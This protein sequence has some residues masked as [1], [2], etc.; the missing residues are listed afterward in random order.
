MSRVRTTM[1]A[2]LAAAALGSV[3][4]CGSLL[5][6]RAIQTFTDSLAASDLESMKASS[7]ATF[8][9]AALRDP[10]AVNDFDILKLP[11][12]RVKVVAEEEVSETEKLVTV[13]VG[14]KEKEMIYKLTRDAS[15][16]RWVVDDIVMQQNKQGLDEPITRSVAE[17]MDLLLTVREFLHNWRDGGREDL[18]AV[19]TPEF[20]EVLSGVAPAHLQQLTS[21]LVGTSAEKSRFKPEAWLDGD[22]AGVQLTLSTGKLLIELRRHEQLWRVNDLALDAPDP[23]LSVRSARKLAQNLRTATEFL[24]AYEAANLQDLERTTTESF[25][26]NCLAVAD[27]SSVKL[28]VHGL[29]AT[30]YKVRVHQEQAELVLESGGRAFMVSLMP[31][32]PTSS[33]EGRLVRVDEVTIY[34][35]AGGQVKRMSAL[36]T[37][38][39]MTEIFAQ[40]LAERD[41]VHLKQASTSDFNQRVWDYVDQE[42]LEALPLDEIEPLMPKVVATVFQGALTEVTVAQGSRALTYVLRDSRGRMVVDDVLLPVVNRPNSLKQNLRALLPVTA[43]ARGVQANDLAAVR[44]M[45]SAELDRMVWASQES[46]PDVGYDIPS[47]LTAPVTSLSMTEDRADL[48]LGSDH[49]GAQIQLRRVDRRFVVDDVLLIA[50]PQD[51]ERVELKRVTRLRLAAGGP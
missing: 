43:M 12:G 31:V 20:R 40:A 50:G 11:K 39:A 32:D 3:T 41:L 6:A 36:F 16:R 17:T 21:Q 45:S 34:D 18:L 19:T 26:R 30:P 1:L 10:A 4:G 38:H 51:N 8:D 47:H 5:T 27:L 23:E 28:P 25:H 44:Q 7:S 42:L 14:E 13:A 33:S 15:G 29:I 2:L 46:M 37:A 35:E 22:Q 48:T 49:F 9:D 24:M